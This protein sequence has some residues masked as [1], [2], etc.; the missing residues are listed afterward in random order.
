M[1]TALYV[2]GFTLSGAT[3]LW[4]LLAAVRITRRG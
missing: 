1:T 4:S 2:I 3:I